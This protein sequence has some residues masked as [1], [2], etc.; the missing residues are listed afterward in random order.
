MNISEKKQAIVLI[1]N[2]LDTDQFDKAMI[3]IEMMKTIYSGSIEGHKSAIQQAR[4]KTTKPGA[5]VKKMPL[6]P[7]GAD[8]LVKTS[9]NRAMQ[10]RKLIKLGNDGEVIAMTPT[11]WGTWNPKPF[12]YKTWEYSNAHA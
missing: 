10:P 4:D 7:A 11:R 8:I 12:T 5:K 3:Q 2:S 9:T 6:I 1:I